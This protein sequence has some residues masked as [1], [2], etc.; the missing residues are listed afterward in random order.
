[1]R[2]DRGGWDWRSNVH[3]TDKE[4]KDK[5]RALVSPG[6]VIPSLLCQLPLSPLTSACANLGAQGG[7]QRA[8]NSVIALWVLWA[9]IMVCC[10]NFDEYL[11][12][13]VY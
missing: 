12:Y 4:T 13:N 3:F 9:H 1:M 2:T 7:G 6:S 10:A 11:F 5:W 8:H